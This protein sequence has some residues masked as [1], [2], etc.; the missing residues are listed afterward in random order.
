MPTERN[1]GSFVGFFV[2]M[3]LVS[4]T[5]I[6]GMMVGLCMYVY[7]CLGDGWEGNGVCV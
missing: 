3:F 7:V 2:S 4:E 6:L 5:D 1:A